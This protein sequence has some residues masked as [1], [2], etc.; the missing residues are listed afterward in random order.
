MLKTKRK[1]KENQTLKKQLHKNVNMNVQ[2]T[3]LS[4][5]KPWNNPRHVAVPLKSIDQYKIPMMHDNDILFDEN[6]FYLGLKSSAKP[7]RS[8]GF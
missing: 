1:K 4:N 7:P 8:Y 2:W 6:L 3:Q 5:C